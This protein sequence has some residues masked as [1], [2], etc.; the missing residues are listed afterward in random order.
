MG[1]GENNDKSDVADPHLI[2]VT[3]LQNL[4]TKENYII[5]EKYYSHL[6]WIK[7]NLKKL[8]R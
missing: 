5:N 2:V 4:K 8:N 3:Q 1:L 6:W 7:Q